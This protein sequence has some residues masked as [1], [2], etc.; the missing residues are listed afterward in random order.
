MVLAVPP[1]TQIIDNETNE[2]L[3][4]LLEEGQREVFLEGGKGGLGN[5]HFKIQEIKDLLILNQDYQEKA[6]RLDLS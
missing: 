6:K 4:D 5:T 3:L 1:G 2:V